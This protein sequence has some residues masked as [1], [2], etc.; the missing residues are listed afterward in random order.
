MHSAELLSVKW[1][2]ELPVNLRRIQMFG[3]E[4]RFRQ[5]FPT[6]Q[7]KFI[8]RQIVSILEKTDAWPAGQKETCPNIFVR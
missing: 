6:R 7:S 3:F 4:V 5:E 8:E 1:F 2:N